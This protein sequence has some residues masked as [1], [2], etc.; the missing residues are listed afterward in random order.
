M[1]LQTEKVSCRVSNV[2]VIEKELFSPR[3]FF[4]PAS[5]LYVVHSSYFIFRL[6][7]FLESVHSKDSLIC[8][9]D[10]G[11]GKWNWCPCVQRFSFNEWNN[12]FSIYFFVASVFNPQHLPTHD[13]RHLPILNGYM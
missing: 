5:G 9:V 8:F 13:P 11:K 7:A 10:R 2:D 6:N 1:C 12:F 4:K 3:F